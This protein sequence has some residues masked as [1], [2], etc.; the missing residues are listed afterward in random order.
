MMKLIKFRTISNDFFPFIFQQ[1]AKLHA[2]W[3]AM[4]RMQ[5]NLYYSAVNPHLH[6]VYEAKAVEDAIKE[7]EVYFI[8]YWNFQLL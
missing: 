4:R 6:Q 1:L 3:I 7:T 8:E 2:L 5:P